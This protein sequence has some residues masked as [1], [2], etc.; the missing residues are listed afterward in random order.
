MAL[1]IMLLGF[2][3]SSY[4]HVLIF[5]EIVI[6]LFFSLLQVDNVRLNLEKL[7]GAKDKAVTAL[8]GGIAHLF[9]NNKVVGL[10]VSMQGLELPL[11]LWWQCLSLLLYCFATS[12]ASM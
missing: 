10:K 8:T 9:K 6:I 11:I 1:T 2:G 4:V 5:L 7:M 3:G 12:A